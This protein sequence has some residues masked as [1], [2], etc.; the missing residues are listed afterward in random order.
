MNSYG[1]GTEHNTTTKK[2]RKDKLYESS[3]NK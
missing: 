2:G 1:S 3:E